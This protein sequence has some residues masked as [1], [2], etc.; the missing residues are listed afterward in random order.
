MTEG[1]QLPPEPPPVAPGGHVPPLTAYAWRTGMVRPTN[2]RMLAGVCA[3]LGRAT[4]TDPILWRVIFAVLTFIGGIG[5]LAYLVGWLLLPG[6]GDTASPV[7]ALLGRGHSATSSVL[8]VIAAMIILLS[9]GVFVSEPFRPGIL[10][11]ILLGAAV[12]LLLRDQRGR[13]RR[14]QMATLA[15][16]GQPG[17]GQPGGG[18]PGLGQPGLGQPGGMAAPFAPHG[19]FVPP[20][21]PPLGPPPPL[22]RPPLPRPPR[23]PRSR[24]ALLTISVGLIAMGLLSL[25]DHMDYSVTGATYLAVALTIVGLGLI[26]G[27]W[28]GRGRGLI[29][30]GILLGLALGGAVVAPI[31]FDGSWH[32]GGSVTWA[33]DSIN[34]V[35]DAY[36]HSAGDAV[37]DLSRVDF[38]GQDRHITARIN[39]GNFEIILPRDVDVTINT[40]VGLGNATVFDDS[41]GGIHPDPR[42]ITNL[43]ADGQGG[44]NLTI[45]TTVSLGNL[46]VHR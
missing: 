43:G 41:M 42:T 16:P 15:D 1:Q 2:G 5:I 45:D 28:I 35:Q 27:A 9:L 17:V 44:G 24:L 19:P 37:L 21:A 4:N 30:L 36:R 14:D 20:L 6:E 13:T 25:L 40:N 10:G 18:Q 12:L 29:A 8:T 3:A 31:Q 26:I 33:P 39:V 32:G 7:E 22:P 34:Q 38:T 46:E 23:P 11:A